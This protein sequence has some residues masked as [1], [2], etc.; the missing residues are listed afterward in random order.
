MADVLTHEWAAEVATA[1]QNGPS[2]EYKAT[3]L[4]KYWDW[5]EMTGGGFTASIAI[6][7]SDPPASADG[8]WLVIDFADGTCTGAR[9]GD[10]GD[11][12]AA[13]FRLRA[14][15]ADLDELLDGYD[16]GKALMYRKLQ[17]LEAPPEK[18]HEF[19]RTIY[20]LKESLGLLANTGRPMASA[21]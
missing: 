20:F 13:T 10:E 3:K 12:Q 8:S 2:P 17:L 19:F 7:V 18:I 4:D 21:S 15:A 6:G 1:I 14:T 11:A 16:V 5:V 9:I